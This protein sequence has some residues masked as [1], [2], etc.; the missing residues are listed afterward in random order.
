MMLIGL[1]FS[2]I[3]LLMGVGWRQRT[4][5]FSEETAAGGA[6]RWMLEYGGACRGREAEPIT[7]SRL[8]DAQIVFD[9]FR[10]RLNDDGQYEGG[11]DFIASMPV[12]GRDIPYTIAYVVRRDG[13]AGFVG[14]ETVVEGGGRSADCPIELVFSPL[15]K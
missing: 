7:I 2:L 4:P 14:T 10:L 9:D 8:D 1:V 13:A 15:P 11:A 6:G 12:D 5:A 3:A